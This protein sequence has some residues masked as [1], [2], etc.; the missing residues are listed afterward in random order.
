MNRLIILSLRGGSLAYHGFCRALQ[1]RGPGKPGLRIL[2]PRQDNSDQWRPKRVARVMQSLSDWGH[3]ADMA[4]TYFAEYVEMVAL[5]SFE[6][7]P[8]NPDGRT[9]LEPAPGDPRGVNV[10]CAAFLINA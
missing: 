10:P 2:P 4:G 1:K 3:I 7:N 8:G 6:G 5:P 9:G